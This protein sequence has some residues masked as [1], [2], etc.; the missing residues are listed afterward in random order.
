MGNARRLEQ[1]TL[2]L[3]TEVVALEGESVALS[4]PDRGRHQ[5]CGRRGL[6]APDL[7]HGPQRRTI[8]RPCA[9]PRQ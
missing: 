2:L 3:Q 7:A 9:G 1:D 4:D 8:D 5:R 6:G